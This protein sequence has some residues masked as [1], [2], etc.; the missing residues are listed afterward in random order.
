MNNMRFEKIDRLLQPL[1]H[2]IAHESSAGLLLFVCALVALV[3]ANSPLSA[4]YFHLWEHEFAVR[5]GSYTVANSLHHWINDGLMAMFFF[6]V[7]LELK[8]EFMAGSC[9]PRARR[10]YR[11]LRRSA[12]CWCRC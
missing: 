8:R 11:W 5:L 10:C 2:F 3:W 7:G 9:P 4:A 1:N 6:V 12:A